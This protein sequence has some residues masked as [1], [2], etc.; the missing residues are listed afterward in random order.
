MM[1]KS[2]G[3]KGKAE[4]IRGAGSSG[5]SS[6]LPLKEISRSCVNAAEGTPNR[7]TEVEGAGSGESAGERERERS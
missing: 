5:A 4:R 7:M 3:F 6:S 2:D 1:V